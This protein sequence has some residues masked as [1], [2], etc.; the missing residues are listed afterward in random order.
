MPLLEI[1]VGEHTSD[2][3]VARVFDLA[4][5]IGTTP[6]TVEDVDGSYV[7]RLILQFVDQALSMLAEGTDPASIEE[8]ATQAGFRVDPLALLDEVGLTTPLH[9]ESHKRGVDIPREVVQ[10]RMLVAAALEAARCHEAGIVTSVPDANVGSILGMGFP[11]WTGGTLQYVNQYDGGP[12]GFVSRA[13]QLRAA[14]G[15]GFLVPES[16]RE[17]AARGATYR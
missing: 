5:Q 4:R 8:A 17:M 2:E 16:L 13:E 6:I 14:Y 1:V 11:V 12:A 15:D 10:E 9:S 7:N 3:T